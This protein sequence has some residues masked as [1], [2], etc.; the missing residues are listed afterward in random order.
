MPSEIAR[1]GQLVLYRPATILDLAE[2][3]GPLPYLIWDRARR[4]LDAGP[5]YAILND[6][7]ALA[8]GGF[9]RDTG[10]GVDLWETW[11]WARCNAA[12]HMVAILR[13]VRLTLAEHPE[14]P[15]YALVRTEAGRRIAAVLGYRR[16]S[17]INGHEVWWH[18]RVN[19][20][21]LRLA[22]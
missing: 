12:Q 17:P 14:N 19:R 16:G 5:S 6:D 8:V 13:L 7:G 22:K 9:A 4:Q 18:E 15:T 11:F 2:V 1:V 10:A 20:R 21:D 3:T